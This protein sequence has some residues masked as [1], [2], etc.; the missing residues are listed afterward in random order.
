MY[1][2]HM[3]YILYTLYIHKNSVMGHLMDYSVTVTLSNSHSMPA[4]AGACRSIFIAWCC[5]I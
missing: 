2:L 3:P 1:I 4:M 5:A